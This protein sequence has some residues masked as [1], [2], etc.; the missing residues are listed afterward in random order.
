MS[1][2]SPADA[3]SVAAPDSASSLEGA[4]SPHVLDALPLTLGLIAE[5]AWICVYAAF[6]DPTASQRPTATGELLLLFAAALVGRTVAKRRP[7][8]AVGVAIVASGIVGWLLA[9]GVIAALGQR[10]L[11]T[12]LTTN[13]AGWLVA[14]AA[15][16]GSVYGTARGADDAS[17]DVLGRG[18][19]LL[20]VPWL[21]MAIAPTDVRKDFVATAFPATLLF[22][23]TALLSSG[24]TR[25]RSLAQEA[26]VDWRRNRAWLVMI[27]GVV[28]LMAT[29]GI[30]AALLL[31]EPVS[32]V[33]EALLWPFLAAFALVMLVG[34]TVVGVPLS[35]VMHAI[36]VG[37]N[38]LPP[39]PPSLPSPGEGQL[40]SGGPGPMLT[41]ALVALML[42]ILVLIGFL[43]RKLADN[44]ND[45]E[46]PRPAPTEER[47]FLMP[48]LGP[49]RPHRAARP[50]D[51]SARPASDAYLAAIA[52]F[53]RHDLLR[54]GP[55]ETPAGHA[56]R[57]AAKVDARALSLLAADYEL[58]EYGGMALSGA[59]VRRARD[60]S[61]RLRD[62]LKPAR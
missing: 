45:E 33:I 54:R 35:L 19:I 60:R 34:V 53:A 59:E 62:L 6:L 1:L 11:A 22:M 5:S 44:T 41:V 30:P 52:A 39:A 50:R 38:I 8:R 31:G 17:T 24:M 3:P 20:V 57:V 56:Q 18:L 36:G 9:P 32:S 2:R 28:A 27:G 23:T 43:I 26:G 51:R 25:L 4:S 49:R 16:R 12:A 40:L 42:G 15:W 21:A 47:H 48:K 13:F 46:E 10:E 14:V 61:R 29:V 7:G 37:S 58:E 55:S